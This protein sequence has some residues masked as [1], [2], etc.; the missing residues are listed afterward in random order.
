MQNTGQANEKKS[1]R[2]ILLL[3]V[4]LAAFSSAM[5][6]LNQVQ[7]FTLETTS[8]LAQWSEK[9]AP[10]EKTTSVETC[11]NRQANIPLPPVPAIPEMPPAPPM[12]V[13]EPDESEA[14]QMVA[15]VP[16]AVPR[17]PAA[18]A[19]KVRRALPATHDSAQ[20]RV[21]ISTEDFVERNIKDA[22]ETDSSLKALKLRNRRHLLITPD[23]KDVIL[24]TLSRS[25]NLR[26]A[27]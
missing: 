25:I 19:P 4:G 23:G 14:P 26:S 2:V 5:K 3:V 8:L 10:T 27:S 16:P 15:P 24:K 17:V 7:A 22:L 18:P 13:A 12:Q 20:V 11:D 9:L 21:F 6:E 1:Y